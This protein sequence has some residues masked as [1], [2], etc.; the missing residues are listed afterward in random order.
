MVLDNGNVFVRC[1]LGHRHWGRYG[2]AGL[3]LSDPGRGILLQRRSWWVH[4]GGTWS[5][6]GGAVETGETARQAATREA[7]EE[8]AVAPE[9]VRPI[10]ESV[11]DHGNWRYTTV[12]ASTTHPVEAKVA[13][14]ESAELRWV[15]L[16]DVAGYRLHNDFAAAWPA[17]RVQ[18]G[19]ELVLVVDGANVV[20][21]RPDGWWRDRAGAAARLR[22]RLAGLALSGVRGGDQS[23]PGGAD[24]VWWPKIVLVVEGQARGTDSVDGVEVVAAEADGDSAIVEVVKAAG[25]RQPG[26][27]IVVVTAD[28][29]LRGR[30]AAEGAATLG[31]GALLAML[32]AG[33]VGDSGTVGG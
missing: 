26:D 1:E 9:L 28:R 20:G 23:I 10:A 6:P 4:H 22:D 33:A 17:L 32:D 8:A 13:N 12:L 3:L 15:P 27:H 7:F 16:D 24:W 18:A 14:A 11:V 30:V 21:S 31:P 2:A 29:E 19:R 5:L 25:V